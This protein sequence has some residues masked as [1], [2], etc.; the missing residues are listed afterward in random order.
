MR[1]VNWT[2]SSKTGNTSLQTHLESIH[3]TEYLE[4]CEDKG[5]VNMLP[6]MR[7]DVGSGAGNAGGGGDGGAPRDTFSQSRLLQYLVNFIVANDQVSNRL[8]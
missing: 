7:K 2:F 4:L 1:G 8:L 6:K 3:R 5:W